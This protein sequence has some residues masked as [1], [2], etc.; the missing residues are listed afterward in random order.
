MSNKFR[1]CSDVAATY[2]I[3]LEFSNNIA[4]ALFLRRLDELRIMPASEQQ[5]SNR[6]CTE[7]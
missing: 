7:Y 1:L 3:I 6:L 5:T 2:K 4:S